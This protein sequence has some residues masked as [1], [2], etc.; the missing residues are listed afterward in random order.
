VGSANDVIPSE[1][2]SSTMNNKCCKFILR[3]EVHSVK[4]IN[5]SG[6]TPLNT[7]HKA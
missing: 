1:N 3:I 2:T 7:H 4:S 6:A 5:E